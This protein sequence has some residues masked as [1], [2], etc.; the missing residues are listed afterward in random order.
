MNVLRSKYT[1]YVILTLICLAFLGM[2]YIGA[3]GLALTPR[4]AVFTYQQGETI[5]NDPGYY[6][7]GVTDP[8]RVKIDLSKVDAKKPGVYTI[9]AKQS[10]RHYE[11]KIR[12]TE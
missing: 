1:V 10:S 4:K 9:R 3:N 7:K 6:F 5:K 8:D 2:I 12:V 11:F